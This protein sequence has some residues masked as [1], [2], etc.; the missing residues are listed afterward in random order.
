MLR[1]LPLLLCAFLFS[2]LSAQKIA[3]VNFG[4]LLNDLPA[5]GAA[6]TELETLSAELT[7]TGETMVEK[8]RSDYESLQSGGQDLAPVEL[9]K[10]QQKLQEDQL[11]I[12]KFEQQIVNEVEQKRRVLLEPI[13]TEVKAAIEKVAKEQGFQF[14][15]DSSVFNSVLYADDATDLTALVLKELGIE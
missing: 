12:Q 13:I 3:H 14:V 10:R 5:T 1:I 2:D 11:A 15:V 8:L 4:N 7:K 9:Q 6:D